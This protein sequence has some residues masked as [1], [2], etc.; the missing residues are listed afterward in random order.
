MKT[1]LELF[2]NYMNNPENIDVNAD[3]LFTFKINSWFSA[4]L[5]WTLIYDDDIDIRDNQGNVGPRTQFKSVLGLGVSY[6]MRNFV[7]KNPKK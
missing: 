2:S 4:S 5:N 1:K 7:V 6:T 3:V